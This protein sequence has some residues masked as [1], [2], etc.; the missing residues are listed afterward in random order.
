MIVICSLFNMCSKLSKRERELL[1]E[2]A[3]SDKIDD[4][5]ATK[6]VIINEL[7]MSI[8]LIHCRDFYEAHWMH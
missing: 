2:F 8:V 3:Q 6:Q 7:S 4:Q 1:T 5:A